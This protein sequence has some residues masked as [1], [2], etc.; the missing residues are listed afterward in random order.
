[1]TFE[2]FVTETKTDVNEWLG[3]KFITGHGPGE[4]DEAIKFLKN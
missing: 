3:Q 2:S 1:M 4:K